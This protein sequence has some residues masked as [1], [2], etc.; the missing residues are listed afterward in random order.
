MTDKDAGAPLPPPEQDPVATPV[1]AAEQPAVGTPP[2][3]EPEGVVAS[4]KPD[5]GK[6]VLAYVI[7]WVVAMVIYAVLAP[8]SPPLASL[9]GAAYILLRDGFEFD[10]MRGRSLG[11]R[12]MNLTVVRDDGGTMDLM[13]SARR[14]WPLAISMLPLGLFVFILAPVALIIGLYEAYLVITSND[15]RRWGDKMAGTRIAET[16]A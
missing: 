13:T 8:L 15:G 11:K 2:V 9:L 4:T 16:P 14:N 12:M 1:P 6:R 7:D 5:V 10:F 3:A